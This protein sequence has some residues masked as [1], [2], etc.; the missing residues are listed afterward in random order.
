MRID[1]NSRVSAK[2]GVV[3]VDS[4]ISCRDKGREKIA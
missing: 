1:P 3:I 2:V 4:N